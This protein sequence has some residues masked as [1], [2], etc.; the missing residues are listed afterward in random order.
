[1]QISC[2]EMINSVVVVVA[3]VVVVVEDDDVVEFG[4]DN[5]DENR[6]KDIAHTSPA[7][8]VGQHV[9]ANAYSYIAMC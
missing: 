9:C 6:M 7:C 3:V 5:D 2:C 8:R 4:R 1:M